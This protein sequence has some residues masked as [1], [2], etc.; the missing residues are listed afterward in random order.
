MPIHDPENT[1]LILNTVKRLKPKSL[2]DIGCGSGSYGVLFRD[3]LDRMRSRYHKKDWLVRI[4]AI[5]IWPDYFTPVHEYIY[6]TVRSFDIREI[7]FGR[8]PGDLLEE[9]DVIFM[10]DVIEHLD[11]EEGVEILKLLI[12][13]QPDASIVIS[14]PVTPYKQGAYRGNIYEAHRS[15]WTPEDLTKLGFEV[16]TKGPQ[17]VLITAVRR[18]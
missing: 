3:I 15:I 13:Q 18:S 4:D 12:E 14:T 2:L 5:D 16:L 9:Y 10:G 8:W 1:P 7:A 6:D 17:N 11:E